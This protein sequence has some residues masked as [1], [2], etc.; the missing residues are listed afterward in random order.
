M[1]KRNCPSCGSQFMKGKKVLRITHEGAIVQRV[2]KACA[3]LATLVL[4][5][6]APS[7]CE[8][9][10][11]RLATICK[12]C[13]I[14]VMRKIEAYNEGASPEEWQDKERAS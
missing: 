2:C 13:V 10:G 12:G 3:T 1:K 6:D 14:S 8:N 11:K 7:H 5:S 9:C 4:A